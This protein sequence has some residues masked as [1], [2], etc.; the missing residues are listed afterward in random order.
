MARLKLSKEARKKAAR[1][2][3]NAEARNMVANNPKLTNRQFVKDL[4]DLTVSPIIYGAATTIAVGAVTAASHD[5]TYR[6]SAE[7]FH[8]KNTY[9]K[10]LYGGQFTRFVLPNVMKLADDELKPDEQMEPQ[11][12]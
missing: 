9:L 10:M 8:P 1:N 7:D 12:R 4:A 3:R 5:S 2:A 6:F 11:R